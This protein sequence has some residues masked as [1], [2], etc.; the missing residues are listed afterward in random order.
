VKPGKRILSNSF[1]QTFLVRTI[2]TY[3]RFVHATTKWETINDDV[4]QKIVRE[5]L[6]GIGAGW[7]GRMALLGFSFPR[8]E[9]AF[10]LISQGR[11][12]EI[13]ARIIEM[14]G[15]GTVRGSAKAAHKTRPKGGVGAMR[16]MIRLLD[17]GRRVLL[18]PDGP[19]GPRMRAKHGIVALARHSGVPV[20]PVTYAVRNRMVV[21]SWDRFIL[22]LPFNHGVFIWGKPVRIPHNADKKEQEKARRLI[23]DQLNAITR[24][25]DE[26]V[27][28]TT[29]EPDLL[30]HPVRPV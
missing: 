15:L 30:T 6:P 22:P 13:M 1:V 20:Y 21:R 3:L 5:N 14:L 2:S 25:A 11:D 28:Q 8:P 7:H 17:Q 23:E 27:G 12:G 10:A 29:I 16:A 4:P 26:I 24:Q 9:T 18:T 19:H